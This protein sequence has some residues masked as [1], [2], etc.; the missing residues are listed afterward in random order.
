MIGANC[1]PHILSHICCSPFNNWMILSDH[2][3]WIVVLNALGLVVPL[4]KRHFGL[5]RSGITTESV[6][7]RGTHPQSGHK[8]AEEMANI[9]STLRGAYWPM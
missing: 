6:D 9:C 3:L 2:C 7:M 1:G 4:L 5:S 8:H